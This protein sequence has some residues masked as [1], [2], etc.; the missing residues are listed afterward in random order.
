MAE[1]Y[2]FW[3]LF[4]GLVVGAAVV[5]VG[6][7]PLP[8]TTD[9]LPEEELTAEANWI[10]GVLRSRGTRVDPIVVEQIIS[11]HGEYLEAAPADVSIEEHEALAMQRREREDRAQAAV[12]LKA[13]QPEAAPTARRATETAAGGQRQPTAAAPTSPQPGGEARSRASRRAGE[14]RGR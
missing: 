10:S 6:R 12:A 11:L 3:A 1:P 13:G 2:L 4:V 9:E 5:A 14:T 8:R 7:W